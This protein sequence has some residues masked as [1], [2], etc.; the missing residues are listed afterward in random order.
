MSSVCSEKSIFQLNEGIS[1]YN[2]NYHQI[3]ASPPEA[4]TAAHPH[5]KSVVWLYYTSSWSNFFPI[6]LQVWFS[7]YISEFPILFQDLIGDPLEVPRVMVRDQTIEFTIIRYFSSNSSSYNISFQLN[8]RISIK[9]QFY[10]EAAANAR[11]WPLSLTQGTFCSREDQIYSN[12]MSC[13]W[14]LRS[15]NLKK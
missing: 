5:E 1:N 9:F 7:N 3:E 14:S 10:C 13:R 8:S 12:T 6:I 4:P 11:P 2:G 15:E